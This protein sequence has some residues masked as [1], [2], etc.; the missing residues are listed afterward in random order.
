[1]SDNHIQPHLNG[2]MA[3]GCVCPDHDLCNHGIAEKPQEKYSGTISPVEEISKEI[4]SK[5]LTPKQAMFIIEYLKDLNATQAAIRAGYSETTATEIGYENL[6]KP[7]ISKEIDKQMKY[8]AERTLIT[9]DYI[10]MSMKEVAERCLQRKPVMTFNHEDKCLEQVTEIV[11]QL[12]GTS[13]EEGV[14]E[15]DSAG[16]NKA[17]ENLARNQKLLTDK[18]ELGNFDG[19]NI[20]GGNIIEIFVESPEALKENESSADAQPTK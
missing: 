11:E 7:H 2:E 17:L 12:D 3:S 5:H 13:K 15:F 4:H 16:A 20:V 14:W 19:S 9:A 10:L 8:R 18:T 1:M 6:T